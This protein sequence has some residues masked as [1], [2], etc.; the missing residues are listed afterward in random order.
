VKTIKLLLGSAE[1]IFNA[2]LKTDVQKACTQRAVVSCATTARVDD[3]INRACAEN[4][5]L[6]IFIAPDSLLPDPAQRA[7]RPPLQE[8]LR[9]VRSIRARRLYPIMVLSSQPE[10]KGALLEAGV[11]SFLELPVYPA[12]LE[13][14]V[15]EC[16]SPMLE[17]N[18]TT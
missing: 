4:F 13:K 3:F 11:N 7:S 16:L 15:A 6:A 1:Q 14:A 18:E 5:D 12:D 9:I 8:A 17:C 10:W 2:L